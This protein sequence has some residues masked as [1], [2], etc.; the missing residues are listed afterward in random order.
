VGISNMLLECL[1]AHELLTDVGIQ[2]E[3]IDPIS[4][5]PLDIGTIANSAERTG[6]LLVVD[7]AWT[8]CGASAE[9]V[10]RVIERVQ[11]GKSIQ[12]KRM[13]YAPTTCPTTPVL[14]R[15]FYPDPAKI[16]RAA[17]ALVRPEAADWAPDPD[18]AKLAYQVQF[19]GPF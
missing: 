8:N 1:R 10:A 18:R 5:V 16:A 4:L 11:S 14:E 9:I 12:V 3:V 19:R 17:Y 2:A 7:N 13:G 15:E 6:R